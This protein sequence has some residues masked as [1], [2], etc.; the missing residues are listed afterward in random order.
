MAADSVNAT[1]SSLKNFKSDGVI[2]NSDH[3]CC[4][5]MKRDVQVLESEV[6]SKTEII[7]I[8]DELKF[9]RDYKEGRKS[10]S[11]YAEKLKTSYKQCCKST[12]LESQLQV[13]LN[14]LSSVKLITNI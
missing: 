13:A 6:K 2:C 7:I 4:S 3:Q 10:N 9:I 8:R 14:E 5:L 1:V 11:T 12:R